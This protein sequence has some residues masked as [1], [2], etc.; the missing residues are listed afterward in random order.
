MTPTDEHT[1]LM[2]RLD[3][4]EQLFRRHLEAHPDDWGTLNNL[5]SCV[6]DLGR[7]GEA[8]DILKAAMKARPS[9]PLLWNTLGTILTEQGDHKTA[10]IFFDEALRLDPRHAH[11]RYNRG[12]A[13]LELN[14]AVTALAD[15]EA[16]VDIA[17]SEDDRLMM[18]LA[19][20]TI[21]I[22]LGRASAKAGTTTRRAW[23]RYSPPRPSS[24]STG[25]SGRRR[26]RWRVR[27]C[28]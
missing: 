26:L 23:R 7:A 15:C 12:N 25:P 4:A 17:A 16:A 5:V 24:W 19:R 14:D 2:E 9:D 3:V 28:W 18:Q 1:D 27:T 22:G 13:F 8:I 20:S 10:I 21:K 11:A 6:R